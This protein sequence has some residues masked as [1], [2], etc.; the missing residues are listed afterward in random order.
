[1]VIID[2][3]VYGTQGAFLETSRMFT[4]R[5]FTSRMFT[6]SKMSAVD[7]VGIMGCGS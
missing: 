7:T 1:M 6:S 2:L 5:M 4:S 3:P